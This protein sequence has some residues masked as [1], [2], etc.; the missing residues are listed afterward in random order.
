MKTGKANIRDLLRSGAQ[1]LDAFL[2]PKPADHQEP[3][4]SPH[5]AQDL[6]DRAFGLRGEGAPLPTK[7]DEVSKERVIAWAETAAEQINLEERFIAASV[8]FMLAAGLKA[9]DPPD[10]VAYLARTAALWWHGQTETD[11]PKS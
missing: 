5:E 4:A 8:T 3:A 9:S 11:I 1:I 7:I 10:R 6:E 2:E